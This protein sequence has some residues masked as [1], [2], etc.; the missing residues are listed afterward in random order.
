MEVYLRVR[1]FFHTVSCV[2]SADPIMFNFQTA[3]T[4]SEKVIAFIR[5]TYPGKPPPAQFFVYAWA[6]TSHALAEHMRMGTDT[7]LKTLVLNGSLWDTYW[8]SYSPHTLGPIGAPA[9]LDPPP[10]LI[11]EMQYESALESMTQSEEDHS[12]WARGSAPWKRTQSKGGES[13]KRATK[14][15]TWGSAKRKKSGQ[16]NNRWNGKGSKAAKGSQKW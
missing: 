11:A 5:R 15:A 2:C 6:Q 7:K 8:T 3:M 4:A 1:A 10:E 14:G 16:G 12:H 13:A 9:I